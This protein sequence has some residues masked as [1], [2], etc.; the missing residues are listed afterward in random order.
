M[1]KKLIFFFL[2]FVSF[3]Y[4]DN[5]QILVEKLNAII[6]QESHQ[7]LIHVLNERI[8][9]QDVHIPKE[10]KFKKELSKYLDK[11]VSLNTLQNIKFFIINYFRKE[12][13]PLVGVRIPAGQ[14]ITMGRVHFVVNIAR[15][16]K[17]QVNGAKYFSDRNIKKQ[18]SIKENEVIKTNKILMDLEWLN[19][20]PFRNVNVIYSEGET[21]N[22]TNIILD[23]EDRLPFRVYA[24][25]ESTDN[26]IAGDSRFLGGFNVGNLFGLEQQL[27]FQTSFAAKP[28]DWWAVAGN[29]IVPLPWKNLFKA[30]ASYSEAQ[31]EADE[32]EN[33][34]GK[35]WFLGARY[36]I[37]LPIYKSLSHDFIIGY[38]FKST[39]NFL[40]FADNLIFDN[41]FDISQFLL[42][43]QGILEDSYGGTSY[44]INLYL[45][46]G[47]MTENN[48]TKDFNIAR[49]GAKANYVYGQFEL[50]RITKIPKG[51]SWIFNFLGQLASGKLLLSEQLSLG[52]YLT[53]RGY[54]EN[55]IESDNG[56]LMKNEIRCPSI[57]FGKKSLNNT[58]QFLAFMDFGWGNNLDEGILDKNNTYL[59]SIGPGL[60]FSMSTYFNA[61]IDYGYQLKKIPGNARESKWHISLVGSY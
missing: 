4:A 12:G 56:I 22:K 9:V 59:L 34:K 8:I 20:N 14:D 54:E 30:L 57:Y 24:G 39:N 1:I 17:V 49:S 25:Y 38:D 42:K 21:L 31:P 23:V 18:I 19:D 6:I 52:G 48:K 27:N 40:V 51:F 44:E 11:P 3:L 16:G 58:L 41:H 15:L 10:E 28:S 5:E 47:R 35:G 46:P 29:Y 60:R 61:K 13:Y 53:V 33:L 2:C 32:L 37:P 55:Q 36:E 43:Y 26:M 45:S 7:N 50:E